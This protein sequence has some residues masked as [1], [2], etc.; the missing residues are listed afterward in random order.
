MAF[1]YIGP[2]AA[3]LDLSYCDDVCTVVTFTESPIRRRGETTRP[4][5]GVLWDVAEDDIVWY[6]LPH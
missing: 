6:V 3:G 4:I 5:F 1:T 2:Y